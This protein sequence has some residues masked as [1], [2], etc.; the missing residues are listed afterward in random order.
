MKE[1]VSVV[2]IGSIPKPRTYKRIAFFKRFSKMNLLCWDRVNETQLNVDENVDY[3]VNVIKLKAANDPLKRAV[4]YAKFT[5]K[6]LKLLE[7]IKPDLIQVEGLDILK[8]A[9]KYKRKSKKKVVVVYE[10]P[11]LRR[12]ITEKQTNPVKK[13]AQKYVIGQEKKLCN[14]TDLI[15]MT[16]EMFYET[17]YKGMVDRSKFIYVPNVPEY[18]AFEN[19]KKYSD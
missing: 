5:K 7:E 18:R 9:D 12:L 17:H 2:M 6:A 4:P 15:I 16:S 8:I 10:V 3:P 11:D 1:M 13:I 14:R 19:F